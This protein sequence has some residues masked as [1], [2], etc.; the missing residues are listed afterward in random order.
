[1]PDT[2]QAY[3]D[4]LA[5]QLANRRPDLLAIAEDELRTFTATVARFINNDAIPLD[6]RTNLARDLH[7][8]EPHR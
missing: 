3:V 4:T 5:S 1:M 7:I 8:P 2:T 6:I